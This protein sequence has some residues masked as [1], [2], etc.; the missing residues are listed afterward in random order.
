MDLC[1]L[2]DRNAAFSPGKTAIVFEGERLSYAAFAARIERTATALKQEL[3]VGRG[4]RVAILS[5]N[6]PDYLVLL[7]ACAR[8]GAMLVPLNWR[9]AV[10]EQLFILT[11][12]SA[13]VLVLE[14]AFA[15]VL[16]ELAPGTS[17][18]GLDFAPPRGMTFE[19]LLT[20]SDGTSRNPHTDLSCPLLIVYTSGTTGRPK[21]AVLRQ[22]ALFWNGV[23]SQHMHNMTSDD[24][25]LTVLPFFHVGG[26]NI[27]T[28]PALQ[29]GATVTVHARFTPDTALATI[30]Q[31][32][33]TLT[34]MVP[35]IIQAVSEHPAWTATD[36]SSLKAVATGST[37]VP[38]HLIE[39]FV[40]RDVPVLQVY[41][42]TETCPIAIYTRLGG[43]LSRPGSTGLA[44]LC[45]EARVVD[46]S[47]SEVP[48]GTPGE[49]AV[50]GP[51]VFFEYWGNETATRDALHDGWYR[52]GDIG[53]CDAD[54]HFWVR[55][56]KKNMIISGGENVY[57]AEVERVLLEHPDV[58]ECA[59][60]GR[61]DPRWDEVP[62]AYVIRKSGCRL[63]ADEL[64]THV[65]AQL[66]R[67]K[68]PRDIVF[69]T[70]LPRTALGK[71]QHFLLKQLDAQSR[72]QGEAS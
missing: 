13:K 62:V 46:H 68:V 59:V 15:S 26:L 34:V 25:V 20:R 10:A 16:S 14:Q 49:I 53:L 69:V 4:D 60:I 42:S 63:D 48:A 6:R 27:Q 11:D 47:G 28:T 9:L 37:I 19:G 65:Q 8:L 12:A 56:R 57:P 45:C 35:A 17:V 23:M 43:D 21:G 55:D 44:G 24:H 61:P 33:P 22:E 41:G 5:L 36:L 32:R 3:G 52:T 50:R 31:E 18:V 51:N 71:V 1:S 40:A 7:Y 58:S 2:I 39:R 54:G 66:A 29:L 38:P 67:Y 64:R 72:A 30:E 70:D